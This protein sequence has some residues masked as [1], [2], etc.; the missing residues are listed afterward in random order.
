[1]SKD[2]N[3]LGN[4]VRDEPVDDVSTNDDGAVDVEVGSIKFSSNSDDALAAVQRE[5]DDLNDR[6]LRAHA[7]YQNLARRSQQSVAEAREQ[8]LMSMA[9]SLLSVLDNFDHALQSD[10]AKT[11]AEELLKGVHIV[12]DQLTQTL[13]GFGIR[14]MPVEQGDAFDPNRH[15]A[16]M[17]QSVE[18]LPPDHV[19]A[20]LQPGYTIGDK[21]L[22]PAKV[23]VSE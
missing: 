21:T 3:N 12:R 19:A 11:S 6:L 16:L 10:A 9:R 18:N 17:R 22:R 1:M 4:D 20:E 7:D 13:E 14:K 23:S 2:K 15:E 8:Q 5:R